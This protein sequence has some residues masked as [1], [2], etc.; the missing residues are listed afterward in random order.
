MYSFSRS[1]LLVVLYAI[2]SVEII[3]NRVKVSI[4]NGKSINNL[5]MKRGLGALLNM[6]Q[7]YVDVFREKYYCVY[8]HLFY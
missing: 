6:M 5:Y 2:C 4:C 7:I 1:S 8:I 3:R